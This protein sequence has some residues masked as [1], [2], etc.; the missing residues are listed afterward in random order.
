MRGE[1][2]WFCCVC[3]VQPTV[4]WGKLIDSCGYV[5]C[6][7]SVVA[8]WP[9]CVSTCL[10]T[11]TSIQHTIKWTDLTTQRHKSNISPL[12]LKW[13]FSGVLGYIKG[14]KKMQTYIDSLT[15]YHLCRKWW[16]QYAWECEK[17]ATAS[18][19][20]K[21]KGCC[22][23]CSWSFFLNRHQTPGARQS[24][25][26]AYWASLRPSQ[27]TRQQKV[28]SLKPAND[29]YKGS[30]HN[31][32]PLHRGI[33]SPGWMWL[34]SCLCA[35]LCGMEERKQHFT[36]GFQVKWSFDFDRANIYSHGLLHD[37][38]TQTG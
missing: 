20:G 1:I 10:I 24:S 27:A 14:G 7:M 30:T 23:D 18:L 26:K 31:Q 8:D 16:N 33:K 13:L 28:S 2:C 29:F 34:I 25:G 17:T 15:A 37:I 35:C 36:S 9:S 6:C 11:P 19:V 12:S 38:T 4:T 5:L 21:I 3:Q 22:T 32:S